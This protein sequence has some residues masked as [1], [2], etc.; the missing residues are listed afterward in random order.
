MEQEKMAVQIC[1]DL[2]K[3]WGLIKGMDPKQRAR[4]LAGLVDGLAGATVPHPHGDSVPPI[5]PAFDAPYEAGYD[6]AE[7]WGKIAQ[8]WVPV[9]V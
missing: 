7:T 5:R 8:Q 6:V 1:N 2:V 4:V 3:K 9:P